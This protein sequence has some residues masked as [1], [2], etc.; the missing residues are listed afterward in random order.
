[1]T[2]YCYRFNFKNKCSKLVS[3][4]INPLAELQ[5]LIGQHIRRTSWA[6]LKPIVKHLLRLNILTRECSWYIVKIP[7]YLI[8]PGDLTINPLWVH[9]Y[10]I[11]FI[12][13]H[14][15]LYH[16][17]PILWRKLQYHQP[18]STLLTFHM[19]TLW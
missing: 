2:K 16:H 17:T 8:G 5:K 12:Y 11:I 1:M 13:I 7:L 15:I 14:I 9:E 6:A 3:V 18:T 4:W 10:M 19:F